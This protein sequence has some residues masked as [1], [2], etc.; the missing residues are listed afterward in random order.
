MPSVLRVN[1]LA[2]DPHAIARPAD[3]ALEDVAHAELAADVLDVDGFALVGETRVARDH[4]ECAYSRE[5]G[6]DVVDDAVG[7]VLL[8]GVPAQ[9]GKRQH[10]NRRFVGVNLGEQ[11][12]QRRKSLRQIGMEELEDLLPTCQIFE[13]VLAQG[14]HS[15]PQRQSVTTQV[16]GCL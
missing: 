12:L 13:T 6:D 3:A 7:E 14:L 5:R 4:E 11:C 1:Q 8:L 9:V 16:V 15:R 2:G 10:R